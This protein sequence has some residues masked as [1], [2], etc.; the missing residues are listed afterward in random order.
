MEG[1]LFMT[2]QGNSWIDKQC[3]TSH[4][5]WGYF[6]TFCWSATLITAIPAT[7]RFPW[8]SGNSNQWQHGGPAYSILVYQGG[9]FFQE[10]ISEQTIHLR[11]SFAYLFHQSLKC[12]YS[13][14]LHQLIFDTCL[15]SQWQSQ[16]FKI[17]V[18]KTILESIIPIKHWHKGMWGG[19]VFQMKPLNPKHKLSVYYSG[20]ALLR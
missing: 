8:H 14:N 2:W 15:Q 13:F 18:V 4:F 17:S 1:L 3:V 6:R 16:T 9:L 20:C 10:Y 5:T 19:H 11:L 7:S 12:I